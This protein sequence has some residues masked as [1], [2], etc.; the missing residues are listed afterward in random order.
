MLCM[1]QLQTNNS[2][3]CCCWR[4]QRCTNTIT[5]ATNVVNLQFQHPSRL[6]HM[7]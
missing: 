4:G 6:Q 3:I 7:Q 2:T 1:L 5:P